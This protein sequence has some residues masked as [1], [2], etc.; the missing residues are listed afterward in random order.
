MWPDAGVN[1]TAFESRFQSDLVQTARVPSH[2]AF[3]RVKPT[4]DLDILRACGGTDAVDRCPDDRDQIGRTTLQLHRAGKNP[5]HVQQIIDQRGL[6]LRVSG[7]RLQ[8]RLCARGVVRLLLEQTRPA[9]NGVEWGPQ[10]VRHGRQELVAQAVRRFSLSTSPFLSLEQQRPLLLRE[11]ALGEIAHDL[12][13]SL[14][15]AGGVAQA[16]EHTHRPEPRPIFAHVPAFVLGAAG[17]G[18]SLD[19]PI[20]RARCEVFWRENDGQPLPDEFALAVAEEPLHAQ[21]PR[22]DRSLR[23]DGEDGVVPDVLFEQPQPFFGV[24]EDACPWAGHSLNGP[25]VRWTILGQQ[26]VPFD[27]ASLRDGTLADQRHDRHDGRCLIRVGTRH[28]LE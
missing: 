8:R 2:G 6:K 26:N 20:R 19:L 17:R 4:L 7:D 27:F 3:K 14:N 15:L 25:A 18:R 1:F 24:S 9:E 23:I 11:F 5:R 16:G 10:L 12:R 22:L 28:R 13:E 21:I